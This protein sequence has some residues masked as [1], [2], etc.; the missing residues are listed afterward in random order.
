VS[1][2]L[3]R[4]EA[5]TCPVE[6]RACY[7]AWKGERKADR[8]VQPQDVH[9][10]VQVSRF[11][12]VSLA[13]LLTTVLDP[14]TGQLPPCFAKET[15]RRLWIRTRI[16]ARD[17]RWGKQ[18]I[19]SRDVR[20]KKRQGHAELLRTL[21]SCGAGQRE[22]ERGQVQARKTTLRWQ[23][24]KGDDW[25]RLK[26]TRAGLIARTC[27]TTLKSKC[28]V[29]ETK[30]CE[31]RALGECSLLLVREIARRHSH[32]SPRPS[33]LFPNPPRI[34]ACFNRQSKINQAQS[35]QKGTREDCSHLKERLSIGR[36]RSP[37]SQSKASTLPSHRPD[38]K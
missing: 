14:G 30:L 36:R 23:T 21:S 37:Q 11:H 13:L 16:F 24:R 29:G 20:L 22:L 31:I 26:V 9:A 32:T 19:N 4:Q 10:C 3:P 28:S 18:T 34:A 33:L 38:R 25:E 12:R 17:T 8:L 7:G 6:G 27:S 1:R 2:R 35:Y 5:K 15:G